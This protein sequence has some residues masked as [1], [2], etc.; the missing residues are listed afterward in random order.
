MT[1][2]I[3]DTVQAVDRTLLLTFG[4]S[5]FFFLLITAL[6]VLFVVRY[7][8]A[9]HPQ[10]A[11]IRG[12]NLLEAAWIVL[13]T[14]VVLAMFLSGW[15]SYLALQRAPGNAMEVRVAARK[16]SWSFTY[17]NGRT[18][19]VLYVEQNRPV[20]LAIGS[21]DVLHSFFAPAFRIKRDAVPGMTTYAWFR[22]SVIGEFDVLCTE[23][24]GSG[25]SAMV[26]RIVVLGEEE[27]RRFY[28]KGEV[29]GSD[30][31]LEL[32]TRHG[33][34]GCHPLGG[35]SGVGPDLATVFGKTIEVESAAG[36]R[37][38]TADE[39]YLRRSILQPGAEV[40]VG[41]A[42]IM[43]AYEGRMDESELGE[44]VD[45]VKNLQKKESEQ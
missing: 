33:C 28:E 11:D 39:D 8:A 40:V 24:C 45:F 41:Y 3:L 30:R 13:P 15:Q 10:A 19:G 31:G 36:R 6:L 21:E 43:P 34:V 37:K 35:V 25:H 42:A 38:V 29:E 12:N 14:L 22:P 17:P 27:F 2:E 20:R 7:R 18:S 1:S 9:R 4:V 23:Y 44:L 5:I 16:W 26:S 32:F